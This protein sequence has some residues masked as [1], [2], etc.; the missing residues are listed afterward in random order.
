MLVDC[1]L[2]LE[3]NV[4][5]TPLTKVANGWQAGRLVRTIATVGSGSFN[6]TDVNG[7]YLPGSYVWATD[8][9]SS[10]S[11]S[12]A[13]EWTY[14]AQSGQLMASNGLCLSPYSPY[15]PH[16][17][18]GPLRVDSLATLACEKS[19]HRASGREQRWE[20]APDGTLRQTAKASRGR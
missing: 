8:C 10:A 17:I 11:E 16:T 12:V 13:P 14:N 15:M 5:L 4:L 9:N 20:F 1:L 3:I 18:N 7:S 6:N 2:L 19:R